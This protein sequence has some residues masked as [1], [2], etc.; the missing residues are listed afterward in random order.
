[1]IRGLH[2]LF[3]SSHPEEARHFIRDKL[4]LPYTDTGGGWLIFDLPEAELG[5]HPVEDKD[6]SMVG[7]HDVS[8]YCDNIHRTVSDL[9]KRGVKFTGRIA[10]REY[11]F[12]TQFEIP[13]GVKAQL[14]QPKYRKAKSNPRPLGRNARKSS[15]TRMIRSRRRRGT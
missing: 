2:G 14:Y 10:E 3:Y 11:D 6:S 8:F 7:I 15:K 4:R 5:V 1:M 12:V 9:K 13:G